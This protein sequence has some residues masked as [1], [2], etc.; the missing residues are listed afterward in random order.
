M[1][2]FQ[3][4]ASFPPTQAGFSTEPESVNFVECGR[5][6]FLCFRW[7]EITPKTPDWPGARPGGGAASVPL[8]GP[9]GGGSPGGPP[10][11]GV[12][13]LA[14]GVTCIQ[15]GGQGWRGCSQC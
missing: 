13:P 5:T 11:G 6:S 8:T 10:A 1:S 7:T 14:R 12:C 15:E 4:V 9:K 3:P 2:A